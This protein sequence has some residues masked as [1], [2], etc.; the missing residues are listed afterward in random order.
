ME[1]KLTFQNQK[2][3]RLIGILANP[4][5]NCNVP[6]AILCHGFTSQKNNDTN[7][8]LTKIL[9][10]NNIATFRIDLMGHGESGG[11]FANITVSEGVEDILQAISFAKSI[12]FTKIGLMGSSFGG[13]CVLVAATKSN[14][15]AVL[16]AKSP[17]C[18][19]TEVEEMRRSPKEMSL[20]QNRG[21]TTHKNSKGVEFKLNYT[22]LRIWAKMLSI[23]LLR[24]SMFRH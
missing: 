9:N 15:L 13:N 19:Y 8:A 11:D 20:W 12:G 6:V 3:D 5:N 16:V 1:T 7:L 17:V 23:Q 4:S 10:E 21:Y 24:K 22:F 2:G 18:D 14:N